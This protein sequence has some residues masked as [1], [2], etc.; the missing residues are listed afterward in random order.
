MCADRMTLG[1]SRSL[2]LKLIDEY[3]A[4]GS[5]IAAAD[6]YDYIAKYNAIADLVQ[7]ELAHRFPVPA[8]FRVSFP[9]RSA[10]LAASDAQ[11]RSVLP[12]QPESFSAEGGSWFFEAD[13]AGSAMVEQYVND[14]TTLA[15]LDLNSNGFAAYRGT[16]ALTGPLR[17]SFQGAYPFRVR[18]LAIWKT[19]FPTDEDVPECRPCLRVE[20]PADWLRIDQPVLETDA[21]C[22]QPA[23]LRWE[24]ERTLILPAGFSGQLCVHYFRQPE[25]ITDATADSYEFPFSRAVAG[26]IPIKAAAL[27]IPTEK[28]ALSTRLLQ[29]FESESSRLQ[30]LENT[31][32]AEIGVVYPI[33]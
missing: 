6:N 12:G 15:E 23:G 32:P 29:L 11:T 27:I 2:M 10:L 17:L 8:S 24:N 25:R 30:A 13:G 28:Q 5:V 18:N 7:A 16:A 31:P 19:I 20:M 33:P 21:G 3:S 22:G 14:W 1:E 26:L 4:D 9:D